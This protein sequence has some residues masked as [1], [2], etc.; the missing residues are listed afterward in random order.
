MKYKMIALDLDG[1]LLGPDHTVSAENRA[2]IADAQDAGVLVVPCTGRGWRESLNA[3]GDVPGL[4][5]G[6]FNTGAVVVEMDRG[7]AV[8]LAD[9]E[10]HL[11]LELIEFLRDLPQ[12]VL[13]FQEHGRTGRDFLVTGDGAITDNTQRWFAMNNLLVSENR[14]PTPVDLHHSLR[15][16]VVATGRAAFEVEDKLGERFADRV[17]L[18]C[19][20]GVP[21]AKAEDAVFIVE[22]FAKGVNKWRGLSWI[23]EQHGI[24]SSQV[25]A[26]GDEINDLAMLE[27]AGLGVAMANAVPRAAEKADRHTASNADHGVAHA[28]RQMLDGVW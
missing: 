1:T 19:F 4:S 18:H 8:D 12:A 2:A 28:I 6:V 3:L 23:A 7:H 9:I 17:D 21:T 13:V 22:V 26:I 25:A 16:G 10:P 11:V 20:A 5:L 15:V 24:A 14:H 27:H